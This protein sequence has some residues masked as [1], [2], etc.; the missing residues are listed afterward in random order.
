[1]QSRVTNFKLEILNENQ[2]RYLYCAV[3]QSVFVFVFPFGA[4][5]YLQSRVTNLR[6]AAELAPILG[7]KPVAPGGHSSQVH[8]PHF[9]FRQPDKIAKTQVQCTFDRVDFNL[10]ILKEIHFQISTIISGPLL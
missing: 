4:W 10:G 6:L 2:W 1:M 5:Q 7:E 9:P 8:F 3:F